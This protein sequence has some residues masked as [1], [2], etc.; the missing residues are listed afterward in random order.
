MAFKFTQTEKNQDPSRKVGMGADFRN[1]QAS[2]SPAQ[3]FV[4]AVQ[5]QL[6][7]PNWTVPTIEHVRIHY[8]GPLTDQAI[9]TTFSSTIDPLG[10]N[11]NSPPPGAVG[12]ETTMAEP[13]KFQTYVLVMAV[14]WQCQPEPIVFTAK[15]NAYSVLG[16]YPPSGTVAPVSPD[17]FSAADV[18]TANN[19]LGL[20][21]IPPGAVASNTL[22]TEAWMDWGN[23]QEQAFF[24]MANAYNLVWQMGNR[25]YL[26]NDSL[27]NTMHVPSSGQNG[28]SSSSEQDVYFYARSM[29]DYYRDMLPAGGAIFLPLERTRIGNMT[30]TPTGGAPTTGLSVY[31]PTRAYE[32]V[33]ATYGGVGLRSQLQGNGEHRRL[34]SPFLMKP[35]VPIGLRAD[36]A[37]NSSNDL[38]QMQS[39]FS[40][41]FGPQIGGANIPAIF[42]ADAFLGAGVTAGGSVGMEPSLDAT[43]APQPVTTFNQRAAFKGGSWKLSCIVKGFELTD[44]QA[45]YLKDPT[46]QSAL[47]SCGCQGSALGS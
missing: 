7:S 38:A 31:R 16:Q 32:T 10:S 22:M 12:V 43:V 14:G 35:G 8:D 47:T 24:H 3:R 30:L 26:L 37:L 19:T 42:H 20:L 4:G 13:G 29:N 11:R 36:V 28:A 25:T 1:G 21:A 23:W 5:T 34:T 6:R 18:N 15:G 46:V 27:R 33:G 40:A 2:S 45:D 9:G 39:W 17:A 41:T 44:A